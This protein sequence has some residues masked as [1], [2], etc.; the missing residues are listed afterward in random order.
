MSESL[1]ENIEAGKSRLEKFVAQKAPRYRPI[2]SRIP[3]EELVVDANISDK[4]LDLHL[5]KHL[6]KLERDILEKGH[7]IMNPTTGERLK[8]IIAELKLI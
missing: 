3:D 2:L 5:H 6:A 7:E 1:Q 4:D 8:I